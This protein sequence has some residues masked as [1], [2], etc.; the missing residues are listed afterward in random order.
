MAAQSAKKLSG[1]EASKAGRSL[2][3]SFLGI[4]FKTVL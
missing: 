3:G 1:E 2:G 4:P